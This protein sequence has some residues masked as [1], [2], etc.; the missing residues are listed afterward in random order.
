M[1][2]WIRGG[3]GEMTAE[4]RA[5]HTHDGISGVGAVFVYSI[6]TCA[7]FNCACVLLRAKATVPV[8][9]SRSFKVRL[10]ELYSLDL[11]S[12]FIMCTVLLLISFLASWKP[13]TMI[14]KYKGDTKLF[15]HMYKSNVGV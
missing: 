9:S 11:R 1:L 13:K 4:R 15:I 7:E 14:Q 12:R 2:A 3:E 8:Q 6:R 5:T 10:C